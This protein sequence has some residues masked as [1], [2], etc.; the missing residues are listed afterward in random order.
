MCQFAKLTIALLATIAASS[1]V[2]SCQTGVGQVIGNESG[3]MPAN[4]AEVGEY[5]KAVLRCYKTGGTRV[6]KIEG[7]LRCF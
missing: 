3:S 4:E 7:K 6:I 2:V 5:K 1:L